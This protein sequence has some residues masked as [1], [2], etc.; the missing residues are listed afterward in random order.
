M[1]NFKTLL[2][3]LFAVP[4]FV[5][6]EARDKI[7]VDLCIYGGSSAGVMAAYTAIK[8]GKT[9]VII[10]PGGRVGGLSSG[11]LGMT[12]IGNKYVVTGLALD[13][14]RKLGVYYGNLENWTF[15]PKVALSVFEQY[16]KDANI[17]VVYNKQLLD[18][19]KAGRHIQEIIVS[20]LD[21]QNSPKLT[22]KAKMFMDCTYEGDLL[23]MAGVSY[24][25]GREDNSVYNE[26]LNGVQ[27]MKG[28]QFPDGVDPYKVK[29]DAASGLLWGIHDEVLKSNGTGDKKVQA[30]N[31]RIALTNAP[32][33]RIPIT[34]PDNY[35]PKR[36]ELLV[37]QKEIQPWK[38]LRDVFIWSLM[39]NN[40]TDIN[41]RNGMS[42]DMIGANWDYPEADYHTRKKIIKQHEDYTKGLLY[43][44]GNDPVV[45]EFIRKEM[46]E[47][48]Y[49]KD[50]YTEN[51]HWSPQ[52]YIR[53]ARRMVSDVV[54]TQHHCQGREVVTDDIGY[55]AYTM[56]SHNCDRLV[57]NGMVKNEGNVE[58][59]GFP[60]FAISYQSIV[61]KKTEV[62]NLLVPVCLSASHIAFGSIRMEPVFMVLAQSAAV[63]AGLAIDKGIAI[64]DV[65]VADIKKILKENPKA[66]HR[67]PDVLVQVADEE[68][69]EVV[70]EWEIIPLKGY[71]K[72]YLKNSLATDHE[73][74]KFNLDTKASAGKY[75]AYY[76][77]P[78]TAED[79]ELVKM[80]VFDGR[81]T[82]PVS[83]NLKEVEI[84]GQ[85]TSTWVEIGA[86]DFRFEG[87]PYVKVFSNKSDGTVRAN[88]ILLVPVE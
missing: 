71:G 14:Y 52:L 15:E 26:T 31:Y 39:P 17:D 3:L 75:K 70:G 51:N 7:E 63:A 73:F 10:E 68:S 58:V 85:T 54:M 55:A 69:V 77:Y 82:K 6:G 49:P 67:Q 72:H 66:D 19:K 25:V 20:N 36:Y 5:F 18:V 47:W 84:V 13:F 27:L 87:K 21:E 50:E 56:D 41:N 12:D 79:V 60:P 86:F 53:E 1:K 23:A 74:V 61:P 2:L 59:G 62:N 38:D 76:Y 9:A 8:A 48:G 57:V 4:L 78:R 43:F 64:Q 24:H 46:Q 29:G 40:K 44:V 11:G 35:D 42:T 28:H 30:Y 65:D 88:A 16:M 45:P 80:E 32:D 33:N 37:R 81:E 83:L 34:K 22:V